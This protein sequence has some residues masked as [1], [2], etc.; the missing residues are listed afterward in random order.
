L[1]DGVEHVQ[2]APRAWSRHV[3]ALARA[4]RRPEVLLRAASVHLS[5]DRPGRGLAVLARLLRSAPLHGTEPDFCRLAACCYHGLGRSKQAQRY[6]ERALHALRPDEADRP[7][8]PAETRARSTGPTTEGSPEGSPEG[9]AIRHRLRGEIVELLAR[10][11]IQRGA[12]RQ[13]R[14]LAE[15]EL[16]SCSEPA[17][18]AS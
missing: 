7:A 6:L 14:E 1:L 17:L 3:E 4:S 5:A 8:A 10:V 11:H 15:E 9:A 2:H 18:R 13:A 12:Y 16:R